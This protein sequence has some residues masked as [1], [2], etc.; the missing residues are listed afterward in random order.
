MRVKGRS[1]CSDI[2]VPGQNYALGLKRQAGDEIEKHRECREDQGK[3]NEVANKKP[4]D[5][6]LA[7]K[8]SN[9]AGE[10]V[11]DTQWPSSGGIGKRLN[12]ARTKLIATI[13]ANNCGKIVLLN[14]AGK[15]RR[16]SPNTSA[17]KILDAETAIATLI[18]P[19]FLS[20]KLFGLYGTGL[21]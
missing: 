15:K 19:Y 21:A 20:L 1:A 11:T 6:R 18:G 17:I 16:I 13:V 4:S 3:Q 9:R 8:C 5:E 10:S 12:I 7:L 14:T 2:K